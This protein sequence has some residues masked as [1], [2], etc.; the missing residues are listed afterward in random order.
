[1]KSN[2]SSAIGGVT[3][4]SDQEHCEYVAGNTDMKTIT[5]F[6]HT[7]QKKLATCT[8]AKERAETIKTAKSGRSRQ[9]G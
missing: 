7:E 8:S 3:G 4:A 2:L 5:H 9:V 6:A 1:M